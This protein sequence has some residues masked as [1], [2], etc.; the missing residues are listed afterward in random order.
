[1]EC[2]SGVVFLTFSLSLVS[3]ER[4]KHTHKL[5]LE[6]YFVDFCQLFV[7][8]DLG[9][10]KPSFSL[11]FIFLK[12]GQCTNDPDKQVR[13]AKEKKKKAILWI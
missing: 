13:F 6:A 2:L 9:S 3:E 10:V 12:L 11:K 1:M 5:L 8:H 7:F 4:R